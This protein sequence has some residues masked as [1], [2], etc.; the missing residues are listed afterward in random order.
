LKELKGLCSEEE[1]KRAYRE[2]NEF[3]EI[4]TQAE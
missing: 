3:E 2:I 1:W 4:L